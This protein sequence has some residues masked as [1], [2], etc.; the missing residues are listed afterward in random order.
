M[1]ESALGV[2]VRQCNAN[3]H[4]K[5]HKC[6]LVTY[7]RCTAM[8]CT[9]VCGCL[10]VKLIGLFHTASSCARLIILCSAKQEEENTTRKY[11]FVTHRKPSS[12]KHTHTLCIHG[13][14]LS[15]LQQNKRLSSAHN[16]RLCYHNNKPPQN[17]PCCNGCTHMVDLL[18]DPCFK[19]PLDAHH[20]C[21]AIAPGP[22]CYDDVEL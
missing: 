14:M 2:H 13:L 3:A 18:L 8:L 20:G 1:H 12:T 7:V 5:E 22:C 17:A 19:C 10:V 11:V 21:Y 6:R 9:Y 15:I 16:I 4:I